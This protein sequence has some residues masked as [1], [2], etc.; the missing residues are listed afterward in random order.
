[1]NTATAVIAPYAFTFLVFFVLL[2]YCYA[3]NANRLINT[4]GLTGQPKLL[5][6]LHVGGIFLFGILP[7][8]SKHLS[9]VSI[10]NPDS[11]GSW[12]TWLSFLAASIVLLASLRAVKKFNLHSGEAQP[13]IRLSNSFFTGYFFVRILFIAA[14]EIW[15]RGFLLNDSMMAF[16]PVIAIGLNLVLYVL[17]H[18]VNGKREMIGCIP[19]G[20]VLCF[21]CTWQNAVWPAIMIHLTLTISY[22]AGMIHKLKTKTFHHNGFNNRSIGLY[23]K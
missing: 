16:D 17:L 8:L 5:I 12:S 11:F 9:A 22:E 21:L 1:M 15:F 2:Q 6:I 20:L 19:F 7:F 10:F 18:V 13:E 23:R 3:K 4:N 14:Y